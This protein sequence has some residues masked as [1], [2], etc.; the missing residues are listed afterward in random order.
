VEFS[1]IFEAQLPNPTADREKEVLRTCVEQAVLAEEMGFD[2]VWCVEHH[3][4]QRY[5]HMSSP[6]VFLSFVAA[7]TSRIRIGHGVVC[8]PFQYNHPIRVA[9][10]AATLDVLSGGRLDLGAGRGGTQ[11]EM[12][13]FDVDVDRTKLEVHEALRIIS[14]AWRSDAFEWHGE[15]LDIK[16]PPVGNHIVIPRPVQMPHPPLYLACTNP[17]TVATAANYGVG[18][19]IFGFGGMDEVR[20]RRKTYDEAIATRTGDELVSTE[21][22]NHLAA[23]CP[24]VVLD[25]E[26][27]ARQIGARGQRFF[28]QASLHWY[29]GAPEPDEDTAGDDNVAWMAQEGDRVMSELEKAGIELP[30]GID[31]RS[32]YNTEHAY[33]PAHRAIEYCEALEDAGADEILAIVQMGTVPYDVCFQTIRLWGEKVIPYFRKREG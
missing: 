20:L 8:M 1:L 6:E 23:L 9:E 32:A 28:S 2:R 12:T 18:A 24:T 5:A 7:R 17:Q 13:L 31:A 16:P 33:G 3:G 11:Q 29:A 25:D 30:P 26:Q 22:N 27:E 21:I 4:L 10:R 19:L 15:A 14:S